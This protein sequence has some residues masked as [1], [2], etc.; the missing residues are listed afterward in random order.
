MNNQSVFDQICQFAREEDEAGIRQLIAQGYSVNIREGINSPVMLLAKQHNVIAVNFLINHFQAAILDAICGYVFYE[1]MQ[2][3][4]GKHKAQYFSRLD[5]VMTADKASTAL[6]AAAILILHDPYCENGRLDL[7]DV[8]SSYRLTE[9]MRQRVEYLLHRLRDD[10]G[11]EKR[12]Y[13]F[14]YLVDDD[15]E[16][17]AAG[18]FAYFGMQ[19]ELD[20][21]Q[22]HRPA[23]TIPLSCGKYAGYLY[24]GQIDKAEALMADN[25]EIRISMYCHYLLTNQWEK[26]GAALNNEATI[27]AAM[28]A[29]TRLE[30]LENEKD[31]LRVFSAMHDTTLREKAFDQNGYQMRKIPERERSQILALAAKLNKIMHENEVDFDGA[32]ALTQKNTRFWLL[33]GGQVTKSRPL[34][35][36]DNEAVPRLPKDVYNIIN[37]HLLGLSNQAFDTLKRGVN[38]KLFCDMTAVHAKKF[39]GSLFEHRDQFYGEMKDTEER[40][41]ARIGK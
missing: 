32:Y 38:K 11:F 37:F 41:L 26:L 9:V 40:C 29:F 10:A 20:W 6:I 18:A 28:K 8:P 35:K 3:L 14:A 21:L 16:L 39:A 36:P 23:H 27:D 12:R 34:A 31:I 22:E 24:S 25:I 17:M 2:K 1:I 33:Q 4:N 7:L 19:R 5:D 13:S 15:S 30:Y